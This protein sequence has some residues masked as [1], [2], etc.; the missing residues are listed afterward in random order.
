RYGLILH[1]EDD[2]PST[3]KTK[4][5]RW[6]HD[7]GCLWCYQNSYNPNYIFRISIND[8]TAT[9]FLIQQALK[10]SKKIAILLIN[11]D[12][13]KE[14]GRILTDYLNA[15]NVTPSAIEYFDVNDDNMLLQFRRIENSGAKVLFIVST[16]PYLPR[17]IKNIA[18]RQE[19]IPIIAQ[20]SATGGS[21]W[22]DTKDQ[23]KDIDISFN[24]T[25]SFLTP[26]NELTKRV[27]KEYMDTYHVTTPQ[28]IP[29]PS[30]TAQAYDLVHLLAMAIDKA[31]TTDRASVRDAL[32]GIAHYNGLIKTYS[33]PFTKTRHD[34]LNVND[35]F[36]A[37]YDASGNI[38]PVGKR[39]K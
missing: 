37:T 24:Q 22:R 23:L 1:D 18:L 5:W 27:L 29:V 34:A 39:S 17:I 7:H 3:Y 35:Y 4:Q 6:L 10:I 12:W 36:M 21:L 26:K 32:E 9:P 28:E 2:H 11:N 30:A 19:K 25:F 20:W 33:P 31:R 14:N 15:I 16:A 8:T 38:V 13:G